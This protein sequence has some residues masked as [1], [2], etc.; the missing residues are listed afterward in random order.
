MKRYNS[1]RYASFVKSNGICDM[2]KNNISCEP[3]LD[4]YPYEV[5]NIEIFKGIII[6][7]NILYEQYCF[8]ELYDVC[9]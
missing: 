9:L 7:F 4:T 8:V 5:N 1:I 6:Y 2:S 3:T